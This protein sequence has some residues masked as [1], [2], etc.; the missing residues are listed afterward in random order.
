MSKQI[1]YYKKRNAPFSLFIIPFAGGNCLSMLWLAK[2][3]Q[4][5]CT[6]GIL[7]PP[8]H[9]LGPSDECSDM[10]ELVDYYIRVLET[11][12][13]GPIILV[14][15]SF[16]GLV[17]Y[18]LINTLP[19]NSKI[20][21]ISLCM[22]ATEPP[23][24]HGIKRDF[25]PQMS[26]EQLKECLML[27]GYSTYFQLAK[28]TK[29]LLRD[30]RTDL[31]II[32]NYKFDGQREKSKVP[33]TLIA[34]K[35]DK[36]E[37]SI[38]ERWK[39]HFTVMESHYFEG[40]HFFAMQQTNTQAISKLVNTIIEKSQVNIT[41]NKVH[42]WDA[43][44][45]IWSHFEEFGFNTNCLKYLD[46]SVPICLIGC[47]QGKIIKVLND[48]YGAENVTGV[49]C[50]KRMI[51]AAIKN[52]INNVKLCC[53]KKPLENLGK[54]SSV[55]VA[56]GIIETF[57]KLQLTDFLKHIGEHL[58]HKGVVY[59][60]TFAKESLRYLVAKRLGITTERGIDNNKLFKLIDLHMLKYPQG[61]QE[62]KTLN[63]NHLILDLYYERINRIA[64]ELDKPQ[65]MVVNFLRKKFA[66]E[67]I[68]FSREEIENLT[69][70]P[71]IEIKEIK[72]HSKESVYLISCLIN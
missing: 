23:D 61:I 1:Y 13:F 55:I 19:E 20:N 40:G 27:Y 12:E 68:M 46:P 65:E 71:E 25:D 29:L 32:N 48:K 56:T 11:T 72:A 34:G 26:D 66:N 15:Y 21:I 47:G 30:F 45:A 2:M 49:D 5:D 67:E 62:K 24:I 64:K 33:A 58:Y 54:Y 69:E 42:D 10:S 17:G 60:F 36:I 35:K 52:G 31:Q 3:I 7:N 37:I 41:S 6:I 43:L 39:S 4:T 18:E 51:E 63:I 14:G 8:S 44:A 9:F 28:T 70:A 16:G 59:I 53:P 22:F 57:T 38:F 50:E